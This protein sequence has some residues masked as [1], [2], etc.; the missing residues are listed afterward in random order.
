M[1]YRYEAVDKSGRRVTGLLNAPGEAAAEQALWGQGLTIMRLSPARAQQSL[2][3]LFPTFFGVKRRDLIIFSRQLAT[4]L[5]S[6]ITILAGLQLLAGQSPSRALR[7]VLHDVIDALQQGQSFSAA[8]AAHPLA[9]PPIYARTMSVGE[10]TGKLEDS[11]RQLAMYLEK[12]QALSRKIRDALAYPLF[13][14]FVAIAVVILMLTVA[15]PPMVALFET[16]NTQLPLPTR[17]LMAL[18]KF[19]SSYGLYVLFGGLVLAALSAYWGSTPPGRRASDAFVLRVP[20][21]GGVI[22]QGQLARFARTAAVLIRAGLPLAEVM[23]LVMQ[24]VNNWVVYSALDRV[25]VALLAGQGMAGPLAA[26]R[27]FPALLAQMVRV[28]EETGTLDGNLATL[29]DFYEEEVDRSV[30]TLT[31]L[32]EPALTIVVGG[33]VGF[34]ALSMVMPMY[35]ILGSIK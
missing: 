30:K 34:I 17:I 35:S 19:F 7:E 2:A 18:S 11:L 1:N 29:A 27:L 3:T 25:R 26:E 9:F 8:L 6:G 24:V 13:V 33:V 5:E 21:V 32:A 23:N 12:E 22:L 16:F 14:L 15:L 31:S 10:R 28:G 20:V 4:L